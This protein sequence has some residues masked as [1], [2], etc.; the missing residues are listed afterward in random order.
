MFQL[1]GKGQ[2]ELTKEQL[3]NAFQMEDRDLSSEEKDML[4]TL[5]D[6]DHSNRI[7]FPEFEAL[8]KL[9]VVKQDIRELK[10]NLGLADELGED[11]TVPHS[12][13]IPILRRSFES[14][15]PWA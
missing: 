14:P 5:A 1:L 9:R 4:F 11:D 13:D 3:L 7:D 2:R 8:W 10:I 15:R 6:R 12:P